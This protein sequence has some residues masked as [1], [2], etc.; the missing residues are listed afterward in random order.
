MIATGEIA[1]RMSGQLWKNGHRMR[2]TMIE[3][4]TAET[5][6]HK[7]IHALEE[8]CHEFD[9]ALPI[10]LDKNIRDFQRHADCRFT[11]DS[12]V[13]EVNF[14]YLEITIIEEDDSFRLQIR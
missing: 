12:F 11:Q 5:R 1:M 13:E 10:W 14:D 9:L 2:E 7:V 3:D 8:I 4:T 6:T